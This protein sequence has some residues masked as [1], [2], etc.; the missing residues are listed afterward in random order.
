MTNSKTTSLGKL[1]AGL[2]PVGLLAGA[3]L[4]QSLITAQ[5]DN[6]TW[7][8]HMMYE[9][10]NPGFQTTVTDTAG[11]MSINGR[12]V[13]CIEPF[14]EAKY[15]DNSY[16]ASKDVI[17]E[18]TSVRIRRQATFGGAVLRNDT[19]SVEEANSMAFLPYAALEMPIEW[20]DDFKNEGIINESDRARI[21]D[22]LR[23][24]RSQDEQSRYLSIQMIYWQF[25]GT[26]AS[27]YTGNP[28]PIDRPGVGGHPNYVKPWN[29]TGEAMSQ[30]KADQI[31]AVLR[32]DDDTT[33]L[34]TITRLHEVFNVLSAAMNR[35]LVEYTGGATLYESRNGA[36]RVTA[37]SSA[38]IKRAIGYLE[39]HKVISGL[40]ADQEHEHGN[41]NV[42]GVKIGV[43]RNVEATDQAGTLT[44]GS[45]GWSQKLKVKPGVY[46]L[47]ELDANGQPIKSDGQTPVA[48]RGFSNGKWTST[49]QFFQTVTVT[50]ANTESNPMQAE[51][52]NTPELINFK[53]QK[54][55]DLTYLGDISNQFLVA[56]AEYTLYYDEAATRPVQKN[57]KNVVAVIGQDG[58]GT[59]ENLYRGVYYIKETKVPTVQTGAGR[60]NQ[61]KLD[62]TVYKVDGT[63]GGTRRAN[64]ENDA[65]PT[66]YPT[67]EYDLGNNG[68]AANSKEL[69]VAPNHGS[70]KV[71]KV[72]AQT[73][74]AVAQGQGT[75]ANAEFEVKFYTSGNLSKNRELYTATYKTNAN[76]EF[77]VRD[78]SAYVRGNV[79]TKLFDEYKKS[80]QFPAFEYRVTE[81]K[82][83]DG[84]L[85]PTESKRSKDFALK[86]GSG[87]DFTWE[88]DDATFKE[89]NLELSVF[90][91]QKV[92]AEWQTDEALKIP[93]VVFELSYP[94]GHKERLTTDDK[95]LVTFKGLIE[96]DYTLREV[97]AP[98]GYQINKQT[99]TFHVNDD[100]T[101]TSQSQSVETDDNGNYSVAWAAN[102]VGRG[103][104]EG[105]IDSTMDNVPN[106]TNIKLFKTNENGEKL[107]GAEFTLT[108][109]ETSEQIV[110]T[111]DENGQI[112]FD[113]LVI[114]DT[115][116]LEETKAPKGYKLPS[117]RMK[118]EFRPEAIPVK[119]SYAIS[120]KM[121]STDTYN[122]SN[123][124]STT[125]ETKKLAQVG[126]NQDGID[127]TVQDGV[128]N[129]EF[130]YVNHTWKKLPATG[131]PLALALGGLATV[132]ILSGVGVYVHSK[133]TK[134]EA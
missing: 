63:S 25:S 78:Q 44:I 38:Q 39:V 12:W 69:P 73:N 74:K 76:G 49:G 30:A 21:A 51:L 17:R 52:K 131:S 54:T 114:G 37:G 129:I 85:L 8:T 87:A 16:Y 22:W 13:W 24:F 28:Y 105:T 53:I 97:S 72:D 83:P 19:P 58:Y 68:V 128:M 112:S 103:G 122:A 109:K 77:D 20:L 134:N 7:P 36:Q 34:G 4:G 117:N 124:T 126:T 11:P 32:R 111:S 104:V 62:K 92:E 107:A 59:F 2:V 71:K 5:A 1:T 23:W 116:T 94:N 91:R 47:F 119:N 133:K 79:P 35:G 31:N 123:P 50:N 81:T 41:F 96:G 106:R 130:D 108:R 56:G 70:L 33:D 120:Y 132:L 6:L 113:G 99:I 82:A 101:I 55:S 100:N 75:L 42:D 84:Y 57:G 110:K 65:T 29:G 40:N 3:V 95:G 88:Y 115:Y 14:T 9:A 89:D 67:V 45:N 80:G 66:G 18:R 27:G 10:K 127:F 15:Q 61:Y 98:T 121:I 60:R 93:G 48:G 64:V 90:K 102:R 43:Y 46:Y 86:V 26:L 118:V 125:S